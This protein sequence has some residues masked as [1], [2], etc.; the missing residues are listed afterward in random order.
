MER[1]GFGFEGVKRTPRSGAVSEIRIQRRNIAKRLCRLTGEGIYR[2]TL[3][4]GHAPPITNAWMRAR[5]AGQ[6]S[7]QASIYR[8]QVFWIWG[9][10][11]SI[12][13][14]LGLFRV[15]GAT[16]PI[17]DANDTSSNPEFG[18]DYRYFVDAKTGF[19][20]AMLPMP[21]RPEGIVWI[22]TL[23][24]VKNE[25]GTENLMAYYT[26]RAS[27]AEMLEQGIAKFDDAQ[28]QFVPILELPKDE[29]W[30]FPAGHS[31]AYQAQG[32][33]YLLFG[34]PCPNV[35]VPATLEAV[36]DVHQY[37]ALTCMSDRNGEKTDRDD[38]GVLQW[39]WQ[40]KLPPIDSKREAELV[41]RNLIQ[42]SKARFLPQDVAESSN[43]IQLHSGTVRWNPYRHRWIMVAGQIDGNESHLGEVWYSEAQDPTG[44]FHHAIK[45]ASHPKQSFYNVCHH[46]FL[47]REEGRQIYFEGTYT[48][49]FSGNPEKTPR[50]NYNQLLYALD[51]NDVATRLDLGK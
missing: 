46:A 5:I 27:L 20:R 51:L 22:H 48:N 31:I 36:L 6:D 49:D 50:Y 8:N 29:S 41:R 25:A 18:I 3:L 7:V 15:A 30:R 11:Q 40:K 38:Q 10:T 14:P 16:T 21:S 12:G 34:S 19:A 44:P 32:V 47:D 39:R 4:L 28:N 9:D 1:D 26:R 35:R 42:P 45:V 24:T 33:E 2:D 37:E 17:P 23:F 43:R 13:Y